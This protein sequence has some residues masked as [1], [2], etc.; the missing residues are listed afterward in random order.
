MTPLSRIASTSMDRQALTHRTRYEQRGNLFA[1]SRV[2]R[3]LIL[4]LLLA[5]TTTAVADPPP[6]APPSPR[7]ALWLSL[8]T[9][10][11]GLATIL[12][13]A[14]VGIRPQAYYAGAV[15]NLE[16]TLAVVGGVALLVGPSV[17]RIYGHA[18]LWNTGAA[19]RLAGV[20]AF[21]GT[22]LV[23]LGQKNNGG[24]FGG[25]IEIA[26]AS[27]V[28]GG[29]YIAGTTVEIATTP[30]DVDRASAPPSGG[31]ARS[32]KAGPCDRYNREHGAT[33]SLVPIRA[34]DGALV[35]GLAVTGRL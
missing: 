31:A 6:P 19:L 4:V 20:L 35:P 2:M 7:T 15:N 5:A 10:L 8:G 33:L 30:R 25:P 28:G 16:P 32:S 21:G 11:G 26:A 12:V 17:G 13:A 27:V 9:T 29:L 34:R 24:G 22:A 18:H 23:V 1:V 14:D 3:V